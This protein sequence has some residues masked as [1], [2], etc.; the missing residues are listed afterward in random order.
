MVGGPP[1]LTLGLSRTQRQTRGVKSDG[2]GVQPRS[3]CPTV[4][5]HSA[6]AHQLT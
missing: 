6:F 3:A 2:L 5:V 1:A 4:R